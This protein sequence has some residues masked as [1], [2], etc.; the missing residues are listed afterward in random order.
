MIA[1]AHCHF[2]SAGFFTTLGREAG[3][4]ENAAVTSCR[5]SSDGT[6]RAS[7]AEL[8]DRWVADLDRHG[9][10]RAMLIASV[11]GDEASVAEAVNAHPTRIVGA[12]M[13]Q[14]GRG[15]CAGACGARLR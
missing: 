3:V 9:V 5:R 7:N 13:V 6:L 1:D 11:P 10:S 4:A 15:G 14:P 2:F 8:A 12:F